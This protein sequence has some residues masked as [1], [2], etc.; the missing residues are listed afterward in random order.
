MLFEITDLRL[1]YHGQIKPALDGVNLRVDDGEFLA[2]LGLS[3]AGKSSLIR[4]LNRLV[5]PGSGKIVYRGREITALDRAGLSAHRR[6]IGMI[7]QAF[8]LLERVSVLTNV[9]VGRFGYLPLWRILTASFSREDVELARK[10]LQRVG[11]SGYEGRRAAWL[12]GGQRQRVAIARALIQ[13]PRVILGDEP[14]SS[15]DPVTAASVLELLADINREEGITM[16]V[17]LHA[18]DLAKRFA[19][20][21]IGLADGKIVFDGRPE[22]LNEAALSLIYPQEDAA[23]RSSEACLPDAEQ[24][25][26]PQSPKRAQRR[27]LT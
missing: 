1:R 2:V 11:L 13:R 19:S 14:V 7:F 5:T 6:E 4:C 9:L 18:V 21:I 10:V 8:N 27:A 24:R 16:I 23:G 25:A 22:E 26:E 20:R 17:N 12:S 3:G 15:L